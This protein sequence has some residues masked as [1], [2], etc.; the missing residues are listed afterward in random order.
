MSDELVKRTYHRGARD[1]G[2]GYDMMARIIELEAALAKA[3]AA[4]KECMDEIDDY[5]RHEY[6]IDHPV[7]ERYR[8]R[9]FSAN[10]ARVYFEARN[11]DA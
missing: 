2:T 6:P 7:H 10:P 4:L 9:D 5:I 11:L 3:D 1:F 8:Q